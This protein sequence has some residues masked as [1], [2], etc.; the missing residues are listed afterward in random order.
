[1][2]DEHT[3]DDQISENLW[4][5]SELHRRGSLSDEEFD[6]AKE[7]LVYRYRPLRPLLFGLLIGCGLGFGAGR[8]INNESASMTNNSSEQPITELEY[9]Q[10][11]HAE[12]KRPTFTIDA[13]DPSDGLFPQSVL[14]SKSQYE[15][16]GYVFVEVPAGILS[17]NAPLTSIVVQ[18]GF[19][20]G[21]TEVTVAFYNS[22]LGDDETLNDRPMSNVSWLDAID[23]AN[24]LSIKE[25]LSPCYIFAEEAVLWPSVCNG[26]RLPTESE[27][28]YA[29]RAGENSLYAGASSATSVAWFIENSSST[30]HEVAL[31][32]ANS[33]GLYDM[34][35]NLS[36]W[37]W[38]WHQEELT[39]NYAGPLNGTAR[40]VR[41]G[42]FVS[43]SEIVRVDNRASFEQTHLSNE[44]GFRLAR[45]VSIPE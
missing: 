4:Q 30:S 24:L 5:L 18:E 10:L 3:Q 13:T 17:A 32:R 37:V 19:F 42:S 31:L 25:G 11:E 36:E 20:I 7:R 1:M 21:Q 29:A 15:I 14:R 8:Y 43:A 41:G 38:D 27:W 34:S 39:P 12:E 35:G 23:F 22:I 44:V 45:T 33:L 40:V 9:G 6:I 28:E 26:Y 2:N 16:N